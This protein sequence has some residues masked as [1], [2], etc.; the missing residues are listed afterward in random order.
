MSLLVT[1]LCSLCEDNPIA[2]C[3]GL[4]LGDL[5]QQNGTFLGCCGNIYESG[6]PGA[7]YNSNEDRVMTICSGALGLPIQADFSAFSIEPGFDAMWIFDGA[8]T[9]TYDCDSTITMPTPAAGQ[10]L[11]STGS[12][13]ASGAFWGSNNPGT[14]VGTTGCLT[15]V[16][17]SDG[18]V[19]DLGWEA[20][21]SCQ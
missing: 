3:D 6:G 5:N 17:C 10:T 9:P 19:N 11:L 16:F 7:R 20:S 12:S 2:A 1:A 21:V 4:V 8:G 15:F 14:R 13:H 18:S